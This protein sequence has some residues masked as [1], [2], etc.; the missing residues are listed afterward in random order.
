MSN[1]NTNN[2]NKTKKLA[3]SSDSFINDDEGNF[4]FST[5]C[6]TIQSTALAT[7][8]VVCAYRY[9]RGEKEESYEN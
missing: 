5:T 6:S 1:T 9:I 4:C 7:V 2:T 3:L 8:A